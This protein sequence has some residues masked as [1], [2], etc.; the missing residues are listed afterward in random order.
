MVEDLLK[1]FILN[2]VLVLVATFRLLPAEIDE[3]V[4]RV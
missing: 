4:F 1:H 3:C 2:A